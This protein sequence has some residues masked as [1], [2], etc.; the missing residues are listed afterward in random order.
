MNAAPVLR[1]RDRV[2]YAQY[3]PAE[4]VRYE[5]RIVHVDRD[6]RIVAM[7]AEVATLVV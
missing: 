6:N 5:P 1:Q 3:D 4:L 7:D 2:T